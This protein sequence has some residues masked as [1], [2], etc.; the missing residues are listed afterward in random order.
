MGLGEWDLGNN[1]VL[2]LNT[3]LRMMYCLQT[4]HK[5]AC[6]ILNIWRHNEGESLALLQEEGL[7]YNTGI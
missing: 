3:W 2:S 7:T 4:V 5:P 1:A 6:V